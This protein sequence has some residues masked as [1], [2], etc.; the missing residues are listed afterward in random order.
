MTHE[1]FWRLVIL[2]IFDL[3]Q[4]V[5]ENVFWANCRPK[6]F[7]INLKPVADIVFDLRNE[8][9]AN[10]MKFRVFVE[11]IFFLSILTYFD[12]P[13]IKSRKFW[14]NLVL[15]SWKNWLIAYFCMGNRKNWFQDDLPHIPAREVFADIVS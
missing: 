14:S 10:R 1:T 15:K 9:H 6:H 3:S 5:P 4:K 12:T 8:F 2:A 13:R 11:K 7:Y